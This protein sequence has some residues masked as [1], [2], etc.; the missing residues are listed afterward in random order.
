MPED[1]FKPLEEWIE[2]INDVASGITAAA[3]IGDDDANELRLIVSKMLLEH[4][5]KMLELGRDPVR[6]L[7]ADDPRY[8]E[9]DGL[10]PGYRRDTL[11]GEPVYSS[12]WL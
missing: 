2:K 5:E 6:D 10:E 7:G 9:E 4:G 8:L 11:T 1:P 12:Q 3:I